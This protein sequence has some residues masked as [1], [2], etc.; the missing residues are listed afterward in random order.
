MGMGH[1]M[2][3][4]A[5]AQAWRKIKG[6]ALFVTGRRVSGLEPRLKQEGFEPFYLRANIGS[7]DDAEQTVMLA[8]KL[9]AGWVVLDGYHFSGEYQRLL[10]Q[11]GLSLLCI[12]DYGHAG[13][14]CADIVLNQNLTATGLFYNKREAYTKLLLGPQYI[15][16][17]RE[18]FS[19]RKWKRIIHPAS[20]KVLVTLGGS[21]PANVTLRVIRALKQTQMLDIQA[22]IVIGA[23][24]RNHNLIVKEI[25]TKNGSLKLV[26]DTAK[27]PEFMAW[28]DIA[29]SAGGSTC[30]EFAF[31]G[32]PALIL[33]T[34]DN[35][36]DN[37]EKLN[38]RGVAINLGAHSKVSAEDISVVLSSLL[39]DALHRKEMSRKG[40]KLVDGYGASRVVQELL[41]CTK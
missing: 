28:S 5:L 32:L 9:K 18:F 37:A 21:D 2:R 3:S 29:I 7:T 11:A 10:K 39:Q 24:N 23:V 12:D 41:R 16:L 31:M 6:Q 13:D 35:Q 33:V 15:L 8:K 36:K 38:D 4:L 34:T 1:F 40:R 30:W 22:M 26:T 17:R 27:M 20:C 19:W 25:G 14:Y